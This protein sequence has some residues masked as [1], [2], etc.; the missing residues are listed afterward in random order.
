VSVPRIITGE[1]SLL[2]E[3]HDAY[4]GNVLL[5]SLDTDEVLE[6]NTFEITGPLAGRL[7]GGVLEEGMRVRVECTSDTMEV[8]SPDTG[9]THDK[10]TAVVVDVVVID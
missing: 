9:E 7:M 4:R 8:V 6:L 3:D 1:I 2:F 10:T 5:L